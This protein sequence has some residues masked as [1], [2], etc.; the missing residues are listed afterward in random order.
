MAAHLLDNPIWESLSSRHRSLALREGEVARYPAQVAPF[1]GVAAEGIDA[2]TALESLVPAGDT[3]LLLGPVPSAPQGWKLEQLA[4]LAQMVCPVRMQEVDGPEVIELS[5]P[6]RGDVLALTALVYPHYFRPRT[7][8]LGRYFGV[9]REGR[10]AAMAGE[11]MGM[12]D[13]TEISAICTHP[14]FNGH[15]YARR[16]LA[17]LSNDNLERGRIPFL[18]VSQQNQ[19][20]MQ[21][22]ERNGYHIRREIAFWSLRRAGE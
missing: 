1:L 21:L 22:Y 3:V 6:H 20:A 4:Q 16:L 12:Q 13:H 15:G 18:H 14:D 11:R 2:A 10:L 9:Y 7:T 5:E 19:R 8:D 17:R